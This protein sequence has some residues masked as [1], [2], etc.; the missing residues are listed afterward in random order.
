[1]STSFGRQHHIQQHPEAGRSNERLRAH[2]VHV[3][4]LID[5]LGI[6]GTE[7]QLLALLRGLNRAK[8]QPH[9][10]LLDGLDSTSRALEPDDCPVI[11]LGVR[12]LRSWR[13]VCDVVLF[14]RY[15]AR[16]HIDVLQMYY[17]DSTYFGV[18]AGWLAGVPVLI[19]TRN[20]ANHWMT[21]THRMLGQLLNHFVTMTVC[22][23]EAGRAAVL[24]DEC[25]RPESVVVIRNG[26]DL[27]RFKHIPSP[28]ARPITGRPARVGMVAN[29][30]PVKGIDLFVQAAASVVLTHPDVEFVVAGEGDQRAELEGLI[31]AFG[32]TGWFHLRGQ[33]DDIPSFLADLDVFV[34]SSRAEG[35]PNA[36]LEAMAAARPIVATDVGEIGRLLEGEA[37]QIVPAGDASQLASAIVSMIEERA[38][39]LKLG[40]LARLRV[41][42]FHDRSSVVSRLETL[43]HAHVYGH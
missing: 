36:V 41:Q 19:R 16:E 27:E 40:Q 11:R 6:G 34:L 2:P 7:T 20:N 5:R 17:P 25:P 8:V 13:T 39:A 12:S 26:V 33:I 32:L 18:L 42:C 21:P 29:L 35:L 9:L 43:Y 31:A 28:D 37:G 14:A 24:R 10:A 4:Y 22:N 30:R 15:L 3:C 23:S 38:R 1:V